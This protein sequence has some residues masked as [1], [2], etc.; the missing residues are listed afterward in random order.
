MMKSWITTV[1]TGAFDQDYERVT[2]D[3]KFQIKEGTYYFRIEGYAV[4]G[5]V[6]AHKATLQLIT[7]ILGKHY[8]PHGLEYGE[9]EFF[10][11]HLVKKCN[12]M[13]AKI[14][15]EAEAFAI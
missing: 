14:K 12:Q 13:L 7:P 1:C 6:G 2:Y 9:D 11:E 3:H 5:D 4:E 15:K 8:Y 10:P